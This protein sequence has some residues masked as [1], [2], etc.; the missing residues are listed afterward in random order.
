MSPIK[1]IILALLLL[2]LADQV[3]AQEKTAVAVLQFEPRNTARP[4]R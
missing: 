4:R 3:Q 1:L 2:G